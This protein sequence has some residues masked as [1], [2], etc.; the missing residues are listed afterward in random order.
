MYDTPLPDQLR[1]LGHIAKYL[2][3]AE[4]R[5]TW[6]VP[7]FRHN[8]LG[9]VE[10]KALID[11]QESELVCAVRK[12]TVDDFRQLLRENATRYDEKAADHQLADETVRSCADFINATC[13][14]EQVERIKQTLL[15]RE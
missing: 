9:E 5:Q 14:P 7:S 15:H 6:P 2:H 13:S 3:T 8:Y 10:A 4:A 11:E 12:L 1:L